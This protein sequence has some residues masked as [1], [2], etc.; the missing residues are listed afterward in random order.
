MNDK[1]K[2]IL[3]VAENLFAEHGF[4]GTSVRAIANQAEA[5]VSMISYYFGSKEQLLNTLI[6]ER[7]SDSREQLETI[8]NSDKPFLER[9]DDM[10]AMYI[11]RIHKNH[12]IHR[13]VHM[14]Y[15]NG[16]RQLDFEKLAEGKKENYRVL[17]SFIKSGQNA[18]VFKQDIEI[19]LIVP[20]VFGTYFYYND[21][22]PFYQKL[23]G[24]T[25]K[26]ETDDFVYTTL[27]TH[28]QKTIK[29]LL[30]YED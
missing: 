4:D 7:I 1:K 2:K 26:K 9:L 14:E 11:R 12:R 6:T 28:L 20:T 27:T 25:S 15:C 17:E 22:K 13:I 21:N 29:G 16:S 8:I 19:S 23:F 10:I 5:N 30:T 24:I 3:D 18:G